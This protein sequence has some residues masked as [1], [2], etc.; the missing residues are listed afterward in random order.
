[1]ARKYGHT[2]RLSKNF[3]DYSYI[4]N[5]IGGIGKT[6]MVYEIGKLITGSNEGT[7]IIT[8]GVENKPKHIDDAFGDVAPDFKTFI[9][10]VKEL[11]DNKEEYPDTKFVAVDSMDEFARIT[12]NYVVN[13]WNKQCDINDRAKSIAQAY[14]GFQKGE[15][16]ACDLMLQQ[17]MKLQNAGYSLL[18]VGHTKTKLKEDVI[19]KIQF[20]QL[21]CNLDNKYYN[22]LKDKVNLVA[23]CY[24]ENVVENVE[25]KKNAFTKKMNKVGQLAD[26]KRVMVFADTDNAVDCKTH[27]PFIV[28]KANFG[29]ENFIKAVR[30]ALEEQS[31]HPNSEIP[32]K[33]TKKTTKKSK[34]IEET[35]EEHVS[36]TEDEADELRDLGAVLLN[37]EDD[38]DDTNDVPWNEDEKEKEDE[39]DIDLFD[40]DDE[41]DE[42]AVKEQIRPLFKEADKDTRAK[43]RKMLNGNQLTDIHDEDTL[44]AILKALA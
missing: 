23:M 3:E 29:A 6:T 19:T 28:A 39:D 21:T 31:K 27:F 18:L 35:L 34:E 11:C 20:E 10:I 1:M 12:E 17:I 14:K 32:N 8:C 26:R 24:N 15:S 7:F 2:Y 5:G 44:K 36:V 43:V 40:D 22:A 42:K 30:D 41:F 16:R 37:D 33:K 9:D 38:I 25:E 4:I 13:E